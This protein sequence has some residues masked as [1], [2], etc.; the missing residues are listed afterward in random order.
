MDKTYIDIKVECVSCHD[1]FLFTAGEQKFFETMQ[2][3]APRRCPVCRKKK[4]DEKTN[5]SI[6]QDH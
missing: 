3:S 6:A 5:F 1:I 2:F 4:K